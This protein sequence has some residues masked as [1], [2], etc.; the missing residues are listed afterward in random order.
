MFSMKYESPADFKTRWGSILNVCC[1]MAG[2]LAAPQMG[3]YAAAKHAVVGLT[4]ISC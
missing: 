3:A 1:S 2:L 4:R